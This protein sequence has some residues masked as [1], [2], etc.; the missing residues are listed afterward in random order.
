MNEYVKFILFTSVI[1]IAVV[2]IFDSYGFQEN[3]DESSNK[4]YF[5]LQSIHF[6]ATLLNIHH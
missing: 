2:L 4:P 3:N 1:L 5:Q 6:D